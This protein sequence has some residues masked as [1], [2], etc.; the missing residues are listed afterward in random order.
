MA[1]VYVSR[2]LI[3]TEIF[4]ISKNQEGIYL[5]FCISNEIFCWSAQKW[6]DLWKT[7][8]FTH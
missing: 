6:L 5:K 2:R 7:I 3:L 8:D 4:T 1:T